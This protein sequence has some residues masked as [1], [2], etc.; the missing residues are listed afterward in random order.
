MFAVYSTSMLS[1]YLLTHIILS[2]QLLLQT[3]AAQVSIVLT[4]FLPAADA[5][6]ATNKLR[7]QCVE[8][9]EP[10]EPTDE[11]ED[12]EDLCNCKFTLA[13]GTF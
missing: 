1:V 7:E 12:A 9:M 13:Y 2:L 10:D 11:D 8:M 3:S 5:E 6:A 4:N